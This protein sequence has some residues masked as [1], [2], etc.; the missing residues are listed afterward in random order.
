M[1][2]GELASEALIHALADRL[3]MEEL[4][5]SIETDAVATSASE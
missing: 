4:Q 3:V 1:T 2:A 5:A